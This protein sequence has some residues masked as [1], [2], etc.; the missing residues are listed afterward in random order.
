MSQ[1]LLLQDIKLNLES[2]SDYTTPP[3]L[4]FPGNYRIGVSINGG[5]IDCGLV[6]FCEC[7]DVLNV[8]VLVDNKIINVKSIKYE[9]SGSGG[10]CEIYPISEEWEVTIPFLTEN[11]QVRV[12][13]P[14]KYKNSYIN[15]TLS[16][17]KI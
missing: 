7:G 11:L 17:Y 6:L 4:A 14:K 13:S 16:I 8:Y 12:E 9:G 5:K 15:M 10:I 1:I 2:K 3:L